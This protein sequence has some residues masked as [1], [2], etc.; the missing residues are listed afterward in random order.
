MLASAGL[1][2]A[3]PTY[4]HY[5]RDAVALAISGWLGPR[6]LAIHLTVDLL[7]GHH[8]TRLPRALLSPTPYGRLRN[9]RS[10]R[11]FAAPAQE[12]LLTKIGNWAE[13]L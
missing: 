3:Q 7:P 9:D 1:A 4:G 11:Y 6:M 8:R 5:V 13:G 2:S 10:W 12:V